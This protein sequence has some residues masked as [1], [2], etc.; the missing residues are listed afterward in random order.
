M[1]QF[2]Q[3]AGRHSMGNN[4]T[5]GQSLKKVL[6]ANDFWPWVLNPGVWETCD[7]KYEAK[8]I[9]TDQSKK[10]PDEV[11]HTVSNSFSQMIFLDTVR[12]ASR[13]H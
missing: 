11:A 6:H 7:F 13:L 9:P 2:K 5:L 1:V 10:G 8:Y 4:P 3:H 12:L